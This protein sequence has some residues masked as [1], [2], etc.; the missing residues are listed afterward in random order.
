MTPPA[1]PKISQPG[2]P[3][4]CWK[5]HSQRSWLCVVAESFAWLPQLIPSSF[6]AHSQPIPGMELGVCSIAAVH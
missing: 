6:P 5:N 2:D 1:F 3:H 4:S